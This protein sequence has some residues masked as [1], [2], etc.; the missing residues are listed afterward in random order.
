[1]RAEKSTYNL[2]L[3]TVSKATDPITLWLLFHV[4]CLEDG[5]ICLYFEKYCFPWVL[6]DARQLRDGTKRT[7]KGA[8]KK[9]NDV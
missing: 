4:S 1:M 9:G 5:E 2:T 8:M 3:R 7:K 6:V